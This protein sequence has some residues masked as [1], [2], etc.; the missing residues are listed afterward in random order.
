M[1]STLS[2]VLPSKQGP[3]YG[4][5][6]PPRQ[7][8]DETWALANSNAKNPLPCY[9]FLRACKLTNAFIVQTSYPDKRMYKTWSKEYTADVYAMDCFPLIELVA[10]GMI[11]GFNVQ[12]IKDHCDKWG[13]SA[14][15]M[16]TLLKEP[17][18]IPEHTRRV[19]EAARHFIHHFGKHTYDVNPS[20]VSHTLFTIRP[21][22]L[23]SEYRPIAIMRIENK[24]PESFC[25]RGDCRTGPAA[26]E[27]FLLRGQPSVMV[28]GLGGLHVRYGSPFVAL[29]QFGIE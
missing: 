3:V 13:L 15:I 10:L 20:T 6:I 21:E 12:L 5:L 18:L 28:Q 27:Q 19:K 9:S 7:L 22:G 11:H 24:L 4:C 16:M 1:L 8:P 17:G 25:Y 23:S 29:R 14:R 2:S 26:A